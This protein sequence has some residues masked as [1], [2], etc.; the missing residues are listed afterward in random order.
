MSE[1]ASTAPV[2][3]IAG[4]TGGIGSDVARRLAATGWQVAGFARSPEKLATLA[5]DLPGLFTVEADATQSTQVEAAVQATL[6]RFG[7]IDAYLH[8][9]GS[10]IIKPAHLTSPDEWQR[11][12]DLNLNSAFHG[13]RAV[14]GPM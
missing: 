13:L 5:A 9:V 3:L 2:V 14:L 12:L 10:I 8:A 6:A 4:I 7:R 1:S 11:T